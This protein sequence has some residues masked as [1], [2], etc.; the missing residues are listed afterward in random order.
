MGWRWPRSALRCMP[1][2]TSQ[3][4]GRLSRSRRLRQ[5]QRH[6]TAGVP[7][8]GDP[9]R[10]PAGTVDRGD[11]GRTAGT[12]ARIPGK[13]LDGNH[14]RRTQRRLKELR[15]INGA[16][17][18]GQALVVWTLPGCWR[19]TS[20]LA[21]TPTPK[22]VPCWGPCWKPFTRATCGLP[23]A[24][25]ARWVSFAALPA[26]RAFCHPSARATSVAT[27]GET[28]THRTLCHGGGVRAKGDRDGRGRNRTRLPSHHGPTR[29]A[30]ARRRHG[31]PCA[32]Q[33]SGRDFGENDRESVPA[34][35]DGE[36]AFGEIATTLRG[37]V[38]TL[39]Y[40]KAALFGFCIALTMYNLLSVIKAAIRWHIASA[41][42]RFP[43][44]TWPTKSQRR[45]GA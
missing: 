9:D 29:S 23:T 17:L 44:T 27:G 19:S 20:S 43:P 11:E 14:L 42:T 7:G 22:S 6:R 40:P 30:D 41:T 37:E 26:Q 10:R 32:E 13:I 15:E 39:A 28:E 12:A 31:S 2:T 16:P 3:G 5:T 35:L 24:T 18:P 33:S 4:T 21:R 45:I 8:P 38:E 34:T 25:S 36:A 1:P